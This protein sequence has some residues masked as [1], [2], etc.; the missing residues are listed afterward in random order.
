MDGSFYRRPAPA[1]RFMATLGGLAC[2]AGW[3]SSAAGSG[4]EEV[5]FNRDIRPLFSE[6]C[7]ACHGPDAAKREA[8]LR[9]DTAA[10]ATR[11]LADGTAAVKPGRPEESL[12][13]ARIDSADPDEVMPPP[14][15]GKTLS[16]TQRETLRRWIG[17]GARYEAHWAFRTIEDAEPPTV[18]GP[19]LSDI[20]RFLLAALE[21]RGLTWSEPASRRQLIRR[22]TFDLTGLP[23]EW[24]EVEAF[25]ED[26]RPDAEAFAAV[27]D[28]LLESPAYGERWGRHWLD[29]ARYADTHGGG[30]TGVTRFPF[31]YT[32]RDYVIA[33]FNAD[34]PYDRFLLEQLAADQLKLEETDP[35]L[36]ALGF[37]TVGYQHRNRHD[38][39]DDQIDVISRGLLGLTVSC[40]RC[41][42]HKFDPIPTSDY[43]A[44]HATLASSRPPTDLPL[45]GEP[46]VDAGYQA[47]LAKRKRLRDDIVREQGEVMRGRLR[48]QTGLY[49]REL[50]KGVPEQDTSTSFLSYRTD[51]LRPVV[52]ERWRRY[53]AARDE[54]DAVFGPW[55]RLANLPDEEDFASRCREMVEA[56]TGEN[57]DPEKFAAEHL[58]ATRP[59]KWN[60]RV[61][62]ALEATRPKS[63]VE[64]ADVYGEVFAA[65]HR[66]WMTSRLEASLEAAPDGSVVPDQDPKHRV[67]NSAIERQLRHHL[68]DP[69]SPTAIS[70]EDDRT[71]LK[72][73]NRGVRDAVRSTLKS[74]DGLNLTATAPPRAM[75]LREAGDA[76]GAFVFLRGNPV[77]RGERVAPRFLTAL[78]GEEAPAFPNGRRRLGLARS[79]VD[80][81]NPLTRRVIVNWVWQHHFGS[82]LVR[83]ADDFGTRGD[84]PT[85]PELLDYLAARFLEDGWSLKSLHRRL[86]LSVAYR[87]GAMENPAAREEDPG[88]TLL[89]R[90]PVRR[91]ELEAMRDSM[92]RVSGELG[93]DAKRGGRPFEETDD[94][95]VPRRSVYGFVNRDVI[96]RMTATFDGADPSACTMK[97]PETTVPQQTLFALNSDFVQDRAK[98]L[99]ARPE[100]RSG[101]GEE[102][103][104]RLYEL[105]FSRSPDAEETELA[106]AYVAE[107][108]TPEA[109]W[110]RFAHVLLASNEFHFLD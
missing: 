30:A 88:N 58:L 1:S 96:A 90:M 34:L 52:L 10:G 36:A 8:N 72:M 32:Y 4:S 92:L 108:G 14:D 56:L 20:D 24:E 25:L 67:V 82:G 61:L 37:L 12:L 21:A 63:M 17:E 31:S 6:N 84:P 80:P 70:F 93:P 59:P 94:R 18:G 110:E 50:A 38:R 29:L 57:G 51:D 109:G 2:V 62:D 105:V 68:Y 5:D 43:Y 23:P 89:W 47:E 97:R 39:I 54:N 7:F 107:A 9:L 45:V 98:A 55:H 40:A 27:V 42:D 74:I 77:A 41:H 35:A 48:M 102:R 69:A 73:L 33:A 64:A 44:L 3:F 104:R 83:T 76:P 106:L 22:A 95:A 86:M 85:H 15:T 87:Q 99:A 26:P 75:A 71:H 91:L 65:A 79:I 46:E 78:A 53:L 103:V 28:G 49:L 16:A 11:T 60:P 81:A 66:Q 100:I 13:M 101:T 19:A